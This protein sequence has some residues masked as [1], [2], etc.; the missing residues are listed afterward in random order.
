[1]AVLRLA[2]CALV[3]LAASGCITRSVDQKVFEQDYTTIV[4]RSHR[5]GG[6]AVERHYEHPFS[7]SA[8]RA[9]HI[10]SSIDLR[11]D[12]DGE[13]KREPA[14][15]LESLYLIGE[16][17]SQAFAKADENQAVVVMSILR[18]KSLGIFD[19]KHLT[20]F[21]AFRQDDRIQIHIGLSGWEV[22]AY[23]EERLPEPKADG[24][25]ERY[26]VLP[27]RGMAVVGPA[28]VAV[29]WRDPIFAKPIRTRVTPGGK[30]VRREILMEAPEEAPE[31]APP[32][33]VP[34][35]ANL[36]PETLRALAD[37]ED[38]R[39]RGEVTEA[40]YE[41]ERRRILGSDS[42]DPP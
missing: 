2:A 27:A 9:A 11:K 13:A 23:R 5:R 38:S 33:P 17:L 39:R 40:E 34:M 37:L 14:I 15:P 31:A 16:G 7:L 20:S 35:P 6:S 25:N 22:P 10:L 12:A 26:R 1:V 21:V 3:A 19:R 8:V 30:V 36:S 24:G 42:G 41:S 4:L 32:E 29:D 28:A 18:S